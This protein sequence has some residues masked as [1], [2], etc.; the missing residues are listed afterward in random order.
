MEFR[1]IFDTISEE[2]DKYRPCTPRI[3]GETHPY[4]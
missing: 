1:R 3:S 2:F 4:R